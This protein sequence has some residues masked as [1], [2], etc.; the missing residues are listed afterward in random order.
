[1]TAWTVSY[2]HLDVYKRQVLEARRFGRG[3]MNIESMEAKIVIDENGDPVDILVRDRG[4]SEKMIEEFM[5]TANEAVA[6][7]GREKQLPFVYR[8]HEDPDPERLEVL[9]GKMCIRDRERKMAS[10]WAGAK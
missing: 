9:Q 5:L 1:M 10:N 8:V 6:R 3:A 4:D 7:F 2:T